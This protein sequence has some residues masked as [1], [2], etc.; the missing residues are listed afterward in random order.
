VVGVAAFVVALVVLAH[1]LFAFSVRPLVEWDGWAI[2]AMKARALYDFGGVD[3]GVFTTL[4]YGPL[5]HPLLRHARG[6]GLS[7]DVAFTGRSTCSLRCSPRLRGRS[8]ALRERVRRRSRD[9][10]PRDR[11]S[12]LTPRQLAGNPADIPP[13]FFVALRCGR[14]ARSLLDEG[15][16]CCPWPQSRAR[17]RSRSRRA[18]L[19]SRGADSFVLIAR[20]RR[21]SPPSRSR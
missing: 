5:Q 7:R 12:R 9:G 21:C 4:P 14:L 2:W 20:T 19:R 10:D 17:R 18:P 16:A 8:D 15:S 1:A 11:R 6:D 3:H 13:A